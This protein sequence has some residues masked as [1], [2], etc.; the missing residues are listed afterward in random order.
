[1]R[2]MHD[3]KRAST[4]RGQGVQGKTLHSQAQQINILMRETGPLCTIRDPLADLG[5][6]PLTS[7]Q[8]HAVLWLGADGPLA[9]SV[10]AQRIGCQQPSVTGIVDRLEKLGLAERVRDTG[11]RRVVRVG[12]TA[13]G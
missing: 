9:A 4:K 2:T 1:M 12:L 5:D 8:L 3:P 7:P 13:A 11:D 6:L 10:L